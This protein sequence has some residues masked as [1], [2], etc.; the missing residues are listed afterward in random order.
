MMFRSSSHRGGHWKI[1]SKARL[2]IVSGGGGG[3]GR[4]RDA[5]DSTLADG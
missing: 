3:A 5:G 4:P 1:K 2:E